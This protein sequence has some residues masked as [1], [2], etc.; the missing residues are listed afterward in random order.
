MKITVGF[1]LFVI[2][3]TTIINRVLLTIADRIVTVV[4]LVVFI[5]IAFAI[6]IVGGNY[7]HFLTE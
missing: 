6:V 7:V 3:L 2:A 4:K 5:V 1:I